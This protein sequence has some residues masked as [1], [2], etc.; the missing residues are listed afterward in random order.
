MSRGQ[1][2]R[3]DRDC[4]QI[5]SSYN[6]GNF[7]IAIVPTRIRKVTVADRHH[8]EVAEWHPG[9]SGDNGPAID[10]ELNEPIALVVDSAGDIY[11]ADSQNNVV[12]MVNAAGLIVSL[13]GTSATIQGGTLYDQEVEE[14]W[15][16]Y[17]RLALD[18]AGNLYLS[19]PLF[20]ATRVNVSTSA[21]TFPTTPIGS[22]STQT[23][24]VANI[25]KR[26]T[27]FSCACIWPESQ[28]HGRLHRGQWR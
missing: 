9:Y 23:V 11:V 17:T 13:P 1:W 20:R 8:Y 26:P 21:L 10:A 18:S 19:G 6:A 27:R 22:L 28:H 16:A 3:D 24:T 14:S 12:R 25:R 15:L 2:A 4:T 7:Y 5:G